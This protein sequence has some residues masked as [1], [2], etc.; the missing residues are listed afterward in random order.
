MDTACGTG[1]H[2]YPTI[3]L[4]SLKSFSWSQRSNCPSWGFSSEGRIIRGSLDKRKALWQEARE[5]WWPSWA[6]PAAVSILFQA[7]AASVWGHEDI[8]PLTTDAM[9]SIAV[10]HSH[11]PPL[12]HYTCC[13]MPTFSLPFCFLF[14]QATVQLN[15]GKEP[16]PFKR[17]RGGT[18]LVW[19]QVARCHFK[20]TT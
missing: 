5:P 14:F 19:Q 1:N 11:M 12:L 17:L 9:L 10:P 18:G 4:S 15:R 7:K 3:S 2:Q 20:S 8:P 13:K 16:N 6:E